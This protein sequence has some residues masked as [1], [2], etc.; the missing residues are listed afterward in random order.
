MQKE[1]LTEEEL[2]EHLCEEYEV[3]RQT[4]QED[5]KEFLDHIR[6]HEGILKETDKEESK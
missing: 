5:V 4:A 3:D 6:K 1:N 2:E